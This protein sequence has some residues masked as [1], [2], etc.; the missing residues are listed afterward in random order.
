[1][2]VLDRWTDVSARVQCAAFKSWEGHL[3]WT[4]Q[5]V[6]AQNKDSLLKYI[7]DEGLVLFPEFPVDVGAAMSCVA[8]D[9]PSCLDVSKYWLIDTGCASDLV[10]WSLQRALL[11]FKQVAGE[12]DSVH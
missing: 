9:V 4:G 12:N 2:A 10:G 1:M 7:K 5:T 8:S 3:S 11:V 6:F